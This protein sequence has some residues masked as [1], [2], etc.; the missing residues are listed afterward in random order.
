[1]GKYILDAETGIDWMALVP[2][3][4]FFVFFLVV[5]YRAIRA[6]KDHI[7]KMGHLPLEEND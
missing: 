5:T 7:N 6:N 4:L 1:M 3:V 2:L